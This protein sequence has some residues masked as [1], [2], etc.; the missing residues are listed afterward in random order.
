MG[1]TVP[2]DRESQSVYTTIASTSVIDQQGHWSAATIVVPP[3]VP[4]ERARF[5][6]EPQFRADFLRDATVA[7]TPMENGLEAL[8]AAEGVS[9]HIF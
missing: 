6:L 4:V 7:A 1:A 9:G 3:H 2:P 5:V 8:G